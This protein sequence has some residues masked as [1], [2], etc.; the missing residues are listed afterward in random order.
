MLDPRAHS[1]SLYK[2]ACAFVKLLF[3]DQYDPTAEE[4]QRVVHFVCS[5][6]EIPLD[7]LIKISGM[8]QEQR[9]LHKD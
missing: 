7:N 2:A 3:G 4:I 8:A 6:P 5:N 1:S 9:K